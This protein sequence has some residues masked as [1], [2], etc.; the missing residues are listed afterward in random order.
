MFSSVCRVEPHL[1]ERLHFQAQRRRID[2][3]GIALDDAG[4]LQQLHA[5]R[6]GRIGKPDLLGQFDD[7]LA[8][9]LLQGIQ[10]RG[11]VAVERHGDI[12]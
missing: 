11:V 3:R 2:D 10:D 4:L 6:A 12:P 9:V 5:P 1:H 7:R 8:A